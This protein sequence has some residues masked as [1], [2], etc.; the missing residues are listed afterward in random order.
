MNPQTVDLPSLSVRADVGAVNDDARTVELIF[1]TGAPVDRVDFWTGKRY[2]EVLSMDPAH[3]RLDRLNAGAPLLDSHSAWSVGDVLGTVE[4]GTASLDKGKGIATVRFSKRDAVTPIWQDVRDGII[5]NVSVGYRVYKF[6]E[7]QPKDGGTPTRTAVDWEPFEVSMVPM[8]ADA[9]ARVRSGDKS[10]TNPCV[11]LTRDAQEKTSMENEQQTPTPAT[12]EVVR[13]AAQPQAGANAEQVREQAVAQERARITGIQDAVRLAG[14]DA[15]VAA[16]LVSRGLSL[17]AARSAIFDKLAERSQQDATRHQTVEMG[18]DARD[19]FVRGAANWLFVR[20]GM[21]SLIA[22]HDGV[23]VDKLQPGEFRGLSL[24]D[25]ARESLVRNGVNVRGLDKMA[26]AGMAFTRSSGYQTTSDFATLLENAMHKVLR[27]AYA[28]Q[29]DTWSAFCGIGSVSDFR[30]HNWYRLGAL[31]SYDSL[32]EAGEFKNKTVPDAEK[33]TYQAT[34]KGNIVGITREIVVNDDIAAV[35]R[36]MDMLGRAGK[37]TIEKAVYAQL[38][39][40]SGLG[41]TQSDTNPLFHS[42]RANINTTAAAITVASIEADRA[43]MRSQ[44]DPNSQE[45]LDLQ[46]AVLLVPVGK[47]GDAL[48]INDAQFDPADSKFQKPNT[49]RGLFRQVVDTPRLSGT[50]RYLFADPS[51]NPVFLVSFLEGQQEPVLETQD[52]WRYNG[53]EMKARLDFGVD[54]VDYRGAVTNAGA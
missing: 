23:T 48:T 8:P 13:A 11:I 35:M 37:L 51:V 25:L 32:N 9:G 5:R 2:R 24:L 7:T 1:S 36:F 41:P 44:M 14:L 3:V 20:S 4:R 17:D 38:T 15:P 34:T 31:G 29:N 49:V 26:I 52:G 16:D 50:R 45:Y 54:V 19:K 42:G 53:V 28:T 43:V 18:E 22:K 21:A 27:A 12:E 10:D 39:A 47:R 40:N 6:E 46:P 33:T 30:A